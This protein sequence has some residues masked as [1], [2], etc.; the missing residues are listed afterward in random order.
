MPNNKK[1]GN[2]TGAV[3][4]PS[5]AA[6]KGSFVSSEQYRFNA[7]AAWPKPPTGLVVGMGDYIFA[8][9]SGTVTAASGVGYLLAFG[10]EVLA[11]SYPDLFNAIGRNYGDGDGSTTLNLPKVWG[12]YGYL[13]AASTASGVLSSGALPD[14][15]HTVTA[16]TSANGGINPGAGGVPWNGGV[17]LWTSTDG[18]KTNNARFKEITPLISS[19]ATLQ[20]PIGCAVQFLLPGS[21]AT[22]A[23]ALP[24][25]VVIASGQEI[26]RTGYP[27]LFERLG[28]HYGT[29]DGSTNFNI[30]DY[31]G[32]FLRGP[33][34][35]GVVQPDPAI[36][37]SGYVECHNAAHYHRFSVIHEG[38]TNSNTGPVDNDDSVTAPAT[39]PSSFG[40]VDGRPRNVTCLNCIVVSGTF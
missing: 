19:Q 16:R 10:D 18:Y 9:S 2:Q 24:A 26:S 3:D 36:T 32:I 21:A 6:A 5:S 11:A 29:G 23:A 15:T 40:S 14:H 28:V 1:I 12:D 39:G 4:L 38:P 7:L 33:L 35:S 20:V 25:S 30:P 34:A 37:G 22:A 8:A 17:T 13:Q 27:T 31:R